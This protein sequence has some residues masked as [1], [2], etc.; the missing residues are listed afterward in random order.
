MI[1]DST[2]MRKGIA[3]FFTVEVQGGRLVAVYASDNRCGYCHL[4][5]A[6]KLI[7]ASLVTAV[8][9]KKNKR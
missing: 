2:T 7:F 6:L 4:R 1:K 3:Q 8:K 9:D 5:V